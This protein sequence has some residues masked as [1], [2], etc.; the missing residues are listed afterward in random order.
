MPLV[1]QLGYIH[2]K[3]QSDSL[4]FFLVRPAGNSVEIGSVEDHDQF[5]ANVPPAS[6]RHP[7]FTF[8]DMTEPLYEPT[9]IIPYPIAN[10]SI[11]RP[12]CVT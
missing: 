11:H 6:V 2:E 7:I 12:V 1:L 3:L 8:V 9:N 10:T 4:P 5:F